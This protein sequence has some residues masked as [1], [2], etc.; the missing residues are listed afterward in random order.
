[1]EIWNKRDEASPQPQNKLRQF[2]ISGRKIPQK[3]ETENIVSCRR[4]NMN[5]HLHQPACN[6]RSM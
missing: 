3:A 6:I 2:Q 5:L 1:M 4:I